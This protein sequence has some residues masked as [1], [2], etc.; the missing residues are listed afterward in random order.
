MTI[1]NPH[2][3]AVVLA[4]GDGNRLKPLTRLIS[5]DARPKQFCPIFGRTLLAETRSRLA[6]LID[7]ARVAFILRRSHRR[8]WSA[9]LHDVPPERLLVQPA[10]RGTGVAIAYSVLEIAARDESAVIAFVPADHYYDDDSAFHAAI[11]GALSAVNDNPRRLALLGAEPYYPE[12]E[13]GWIQPGARNQVERF[14]EKPALDV[15]RELLRRGFLWN[16]FVMA[17][18]AGTFIE[19]IADA[20]P[21]L[22][23]ALDKL[24]RSGGLQTRRAKKLYRALAPLDFSQH[25]LSISPGRLMVLPLGNV[26]WSDLG[27]PERVIATMAEAGIKPHWAET[28]ANKATA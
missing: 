10:N 13:Y 5:G 23:P 21:D 18:R 11:A 19:L 24:R 15:A 14:W 17:G 20:A 27:K 28:F 9:E 1:E 6:P 4:G 16:T 26:R 2:A 7:S 3:W 22:V 12:T 8:F 25:V